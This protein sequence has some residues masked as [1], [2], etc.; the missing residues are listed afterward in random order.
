MRPEL[1][2]WGSFLCL[3][4]SASP[5]HA[6]KRTH[7]CLAATPAQPLE[8]HPFRL[9][10]S[11]AM[12]Q[13]PP[14]QL[15]AGPRPHRL[16]L[17]GRWGPTKAPP[18][19][20]EMKITRPRA[21]TPER[22]QTVK[23]FLHRGNRAASRQPAVK[24]LWQERPAPAPSRPL[25]MRRWHADR[26][27]STVRAE[28]AEAT[29]TCSEAPPCQT[30]LETKTPESPPARAL[31]E[32]PLRSRHPRDPA[33]SSERTHSRVSRS[34]RDRAEELRRT[35]TLGCSIWIRSRPRRYLY[36]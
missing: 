28:T 31:A 35:G 17:A 11:M 20:P 24:E 26:F 7:H 15:A 10:V 27:R 18:K 4:G 1:P 16:R 22:G 3:G 25:T 5:V 30:I 13:A 14:P 6:E 12:N 29:Q 8:T 34:R 19:L 2:S 9:P 36:S 23:L 33:A 21:V 32:P